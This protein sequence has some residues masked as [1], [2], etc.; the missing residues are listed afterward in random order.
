MLLAG[1]KGRGRGDEARRN[2][3]AAWTKLRGMNQVVHMSTLDHAARH[4]AARPHDV[5]GLRCAGVKGRSRNQHPG[6]GGVGVLRS[7]GAT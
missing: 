4:A 5:A 6:E 1:K 3:H 2:P 7:G